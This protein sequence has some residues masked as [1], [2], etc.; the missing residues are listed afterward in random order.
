MY[1]AQADR[2]PQPYEETKAED[3]FKNES[4]PS[5]PTP[6][7]DNE[8]HYVKDNIAPLFWNL[9]DGERRL[10]ESTGVDEKKAENL[11]SENQKTASSAR[12]SWLGK[13]SNREKLQ[14][15]PQDVITVDFC[16]GFIDFNTLRLVLP[17][18]GLY[19]DLQKYWDGQPV[20]YVAKNLK[21]NQVYFVVQYVSY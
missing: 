16:N 13:A 11:S 20:R 15:T 10:D 17:Y 5:F 2:A 1:R 6:D 12:A 19:F 21:T 18:G 8:Q 3:L 14:I 9:K 7:G 4:W